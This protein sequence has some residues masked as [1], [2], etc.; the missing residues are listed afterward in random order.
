MSTETIASVILRMKDEASAVAGEAAEEVKKLKEEVEDAQE[1]LDDLANPLEDGGHAL[2]DLGDRSQNAGK[3]LD[4][5]GDGAGRT[6][7][8]ATKLAGALGMVNPEL[9]G[10]A[11][12]VADLAD[13]LEVAESAAAA[14]GIGMGSVLTVLLPVAIALAAGA[15]AWKHYSDQLEEAEEKMNRAAEAAQR[16][17][18]ATSGIADTEALARLRAQVAL[19]EENQDVLDAV[20]AQ[21]QAEAQMAGARQE[22][23]ARLLE[24]SQ[25]RVGVQQELDKLERESQGMEKSVAELARASELNGQLQQLTGTFN[26]QKEAVEGLDARTANLAASYLD[27][28]AGARQLKEA[29]EAEAEA[30]KQAEADKAAARAAGKA[31]ADANP[32]EDPQEVAAKAKAAAAA[33]AQVVK[34][35]MQEAEALFQPQSNPA[36]AMLRDFYSSLEALVPPETLSATDQLAGLEADL[37]TAM[38]R[39]LLSAQAAEEASA[40]L[41]AARGELAKETAAANVAEAQRAVATAA[42]GPS[43]VLNVVASSGPWG[44]MI[45]TLI[46]LIANFD[47]TLA[48]FQ[49]FH[50]DF[51][52]T[53][54]QFPQILA[55]HLE[56]TLSSSM[57]AMLTAP[58]DFIQSLADSF[59][60]MMESFAS[61]LPEMLSTLLE[62]LLVAM[63]TAASEF[64]SAILDTDTWKQAAETFVQSMKDSFVDFGGSGDG[65]PLGT[66]GNILTGGLVGSFDSGSDGVARSGLALVHQNER[67]VTANGGASGRTAQMMRDRADGGGG[68]H[69]HISGFALGTPDQLVRALNRDF[70]SNGRRL[71][72][73]S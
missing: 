43:A 39:G 70:G 12:S 45:A 62:Q 1:A 54:S 34:D 2:D 44:A 73:R 3:H 24:T 68:D 55:D 65:D 49:Q 33:A 46:D 58:A 56:E 64:L 7:Q 48:S 17:Q 31:L 69:L 71:K 6:G 40:R 63:P 18:D 8:A 15:V 38:S 72:W 4:N 14:L 11:M 52:E 41:A 23:E 61:F 47:D 37:A 35:A 5:L 19:G 27:A 25:K 13:V 53:F 20:L 9:G 28:T 66:A 67:I 22:L 21:Q 29:E 26:Q 57:E 50:V 59:P 42:G 16:M 51:W 36:A 32:G 60:Q 10:V 30:V